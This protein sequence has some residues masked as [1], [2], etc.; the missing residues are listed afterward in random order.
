MVGELDPHGNA[1]AMGEVVL[2]RHAAATGQHASAPLSADGYRQA[3]EL[4]EFLRRFEIDR[5]VS[6]PFR[7]AVESVEPFANHRG[8][9]I[10]TDA[11]LV[12]RVLS[13]R[14]LPDWR[15]HLRRSFEEPDY[16]LLD[17]ESSRVAQARATAA[18]LGAAAG[19][20]RSLVVTHGN[21]LALILKWVDSEVG[22]EV[23]AQLS[24]PDVFVIHTDGPGPRRFRRVW[25][26]ER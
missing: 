22:Y 5:V 3:V 12:E 7:R 6:S 18:V 17:G 20:R 19:G 23:W 24:N 26:E 15:E 9:A 2:V 13:A 4:A 11:R 10:E 1:D 16:C 25:T 8:L 14:S 21:L